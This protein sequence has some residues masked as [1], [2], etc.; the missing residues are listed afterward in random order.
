MLKYNEAILILIGD[1]K[2]NIF[3]KLKNKIKFNS[4]RVI[5][6]EFIDSLYLFFKE[7][8]NNFNTLFILPRI[9]GNGVSNLMSACA[10]VPTTIFKFNDA[11]GKWIPSKYF[12]E[13]KEEFINQ[14]NKFIQDGK[15]RE[16]FINDFEYFKKEKRNTGEKFFLGLLK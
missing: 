16:E 13:T 10:K 5:C 8:N 1:S 11:E 2:K 3:S 14:I 9:T 15:K 12:I 7:L 6:I 4:N